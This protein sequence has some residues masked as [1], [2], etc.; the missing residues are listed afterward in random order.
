MNDNLLELIT[1]LKINRAIEREY[2]RIASNLTISEYR[3]IMAQDN[4]RGMNCLELS[5]AMGLSPSRSSRVIDNLV[6]KGYFTRRIDENDRRSVAVTLSKKGREVKEKIK[7]NQQ[8]LEDNLEK[9]LSDE[10]VN[11]IKRSLKILLEYFE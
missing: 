4:D 5:V 2:T 6:K 11:N 10:M 1:S 9:M 8:N 3:G 7:K